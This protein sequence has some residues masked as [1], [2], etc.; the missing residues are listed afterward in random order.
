MDRA[1]ITYD[2]Q[3][4]TERKDGYYQRGRRLLHRYVYTREVGPIPPRWHVHHSDHDK[5]NN[6]ASNLV[7]LS[8]THHAH[9]HDGNRGYDWHAAGGH[10][11]VAARP[12]R[13]ATCRICGAEFT[14]RHTT[15]ALYCS[16]ACKDRGAPSRAHEPRVCSVCG[17]GFTC[18]KRN[19]ART[20]SPRCRSV[21]AYAA[22]QGL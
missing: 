15:D 7:A 20:C 11:S 16:P 13:T 12:T 1:K 3:V 17:T 6:A 9:E 4:W 5:A 14:H 19:A 21:A 8:P 2:G 22:R 10:A 18:P